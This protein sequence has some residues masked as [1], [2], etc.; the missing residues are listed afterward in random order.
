MQ[1]NPKHLMKPSGS[2]ESQIVPARLASIDILPV[3]HLLCPS[4]S[5]DERSSPSLRDI[6]HGIVEA[7]HDFP[8]LRI[9]IYGIINSFGTFSMDYKTLKHAMRQ[10]E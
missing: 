10:A 4:S 1:P 3:Y 5:S 7:Q 9:S 6:V 8:H 2:L